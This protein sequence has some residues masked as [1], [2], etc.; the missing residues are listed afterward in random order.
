MVCQSWW[1]QNRDFAMKKQ[2]VFA[3]FGN[4]QTQNIRK[5]KVLVVGNGVRSDFRFPM[6]RQQSRQQR[7]NNEKSMRFLENLGIPTVRAHSLDFAMK[8]NG[9]LT[10]GSQ[11]R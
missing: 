6:T 7:N 5:M 8:T 1:T 3:T 2:M 9:C 10:F 11:D 4:P